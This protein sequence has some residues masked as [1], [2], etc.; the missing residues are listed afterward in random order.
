M[1]A[2][3]LL[4]RQLQAEEDR[5]VAQAR[6][7]QGT[8]GEQ[9]FQARLQGGLHGVHQYEDET[10]QAMA[11]SCIPDDELRE[12]AQQ[13][14]HEARSRGEDLAEQDA[15]AKQL[16]MWFKHTFFTW[17]NNPACQRCGNKET[18][19]KG[20]AQPSPEDLEHGAGRVELYACPS[21]LADTR[22]PRYNSPG[23]L[24]ETRSGR[25]GEWANCFVLCC[26][27][28]GL[29]S[30]YILDVTDHVWAEYY[31]DAMQRWVH[32]D[33]CEAAYDTPHLYESGW[34]KKLSYV[35]G[36]SINGVTDVTR[37]YTKKWDEVLSRRTQVSEIWLMSACLALTQRLRS[38]VSLDNRNQ[39][40]AKDDAEQRQLTQTVPEN[41][42]QTDN[43]PGRQTGTV[44]WRAARGELGTEPKERAAEAAA[45]SS[46]AASAD[47]A[48]DSTATPLTTT[49]SLHS[50]KLDDISVAESLLEGVAAAAAAGQIEASAPMAAH[51]VATETPQQTSAPAPPASRAPA[52]PRKLLSKASAAGTD[53]AGSGEQSEM[54]LSRSMQ[55]RL[56]IA[57]DV[58]RT[59]TVRKAFAATVQ[60]EFERLMAEGGITA[61]EAANMALKHA[62]A[63]QHAQA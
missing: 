50:H 32:L 60:Q 49:P 8:G 38:Q 58:K 61:N 7:L 46:A 2:D 6:R 29:D 41:S 63:Q 30:R 59:A 56:R 3:E 54:S 27:A 45:S 24:L 55:E 39:L 11:L 25:C 52:A 12:K 21:C 57:E 15:M 20:M 35:I 53:S 10:L 48:K 23:K 40:K 37:R 34:G 9:A 28:I 42:A 16:L 4:A 22:F 17:V 26:R 62:V 14:M 43:L 33:P 18:Q 31:S 51:S 1:D 13:Q 44:E 47:V 5:A 19:A 36:F